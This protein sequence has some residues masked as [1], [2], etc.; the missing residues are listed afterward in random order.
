MLGA[1]FPRPLVVEPRGGRPLRGLTFGGGSEGGGSFPAADAA[2]TVMLVVSLFWVADGSNPLDRP[3]GLI[4]L[5][6]SAPG[7]IGDLGDVSPSGNSVFFHFVEE[8]DVLIGDSFGCLFFPF[9]A[10][11]GVCWLRGRCGG[12]G[13]YGDAMGPGGVYGGALP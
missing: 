13:G 5:I 2:V 6:S 8:T 7:W 3:L 9:R 12:Y 1:R 10:E 4:G 11:T